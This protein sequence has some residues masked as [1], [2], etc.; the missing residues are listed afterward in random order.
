MRKHLPFFHFCRSRTDVSDNHMPAGMLI[1]SA[2]AQ[3][4]SRCDETKKPGDNH[5]NVLVG[6]MRLK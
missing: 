5:R 2:V 3:P 6:A 4:R 1:A